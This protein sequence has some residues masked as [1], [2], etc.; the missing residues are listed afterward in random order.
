[1]ASHDINPDKATMKNPLVTFTGTS[2]GNL[3][4]SWQTGDG[5]QYS[6]ST[7]THTY[8]EEGFYDAVLEVTNEYGCVDTEEFTVEVTPKYLIQVPNAFTPNGDGINDKLIVTGN[9]VQEIR[10]TI[11]N[12]WG[13]QVLNYHYINPGSDATTDFE[14]WTPEND[15]KTALFGTYVYRVFFMDL[16]GETTEQ[17]GSFILFR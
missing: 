16:N 2:V 3:Q 9:G 1:M 6:D 14:V 17:T 12:K 7:F 4:Y 5:T 10:F 15:D 11:H 13:S 8:T